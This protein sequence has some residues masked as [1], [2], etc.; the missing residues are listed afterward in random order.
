MQPSPPTPIFGAA[1]TFGAGTG[2]AGF[3]G[4]KTETTAAAAEET[5]EGGDEAE[6]GGAEAG[7]LAVQHCLC[8]RL[9]ASAA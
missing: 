2:F 7:K 5:E 1:S 9:R 6:E 3:T 8:A 4:V